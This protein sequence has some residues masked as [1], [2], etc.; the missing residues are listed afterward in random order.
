MAGGLAAVAGHANYANAFPVA[1]SGSKLTLRLRPL[2]VPQEA[3]GAL[4]PPCIVPC[5]GSCKHLCQCV[6]P[7]GGAMWGFS[8]RQLCCSL[9]F[10]V[11][12]GTTVSLRSVV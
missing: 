1:G 4:S 8:V 7:D 12:A 10:G 9:G 3:V 5:P 11:R 2:R 6:R